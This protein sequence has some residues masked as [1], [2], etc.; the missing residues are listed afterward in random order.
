MDGSQT[1]E[2]VRVSRNFPAAGG[3]LSEGSE[4]LLP[5]EVC[6]PDFT[7]PDFVEDLGWLLSPHRGTATIKAYHSMHLYLAFHRM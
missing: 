4:T 7:S 1:D 6:Y 5:Q 3:E 2:T